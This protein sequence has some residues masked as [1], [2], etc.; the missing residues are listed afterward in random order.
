A[1]AAARRG[2][3]QVLVLR[4]SYVAFPEMLGFLAGGSGKDASREREPVPH[5]RSYVRPEDVGRAFALAVEVPYAGLETF[6]V[7]ASDSFIDEPTLEHVKRCYGAVPKLSRPDLYAGNPRA[8]VFDNS[9]AAERLGWH[10]TGS[11]PEL[12]RTSAEAT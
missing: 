1:A 2:K 3:L 5:L 8:S 10:P 6:F 7:T 12:K 4:P 9:R 11:W